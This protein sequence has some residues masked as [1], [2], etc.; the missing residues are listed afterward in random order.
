MNSYFTYTLLHFDAAS[1]PTVYRQDQ[2]TDKTQHKLFL[3]E[4][5]DTFIL[6]QSEIC[7]TYLP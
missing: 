2:N 6:Y 5:N 4:L 7:H 3:N 1:N